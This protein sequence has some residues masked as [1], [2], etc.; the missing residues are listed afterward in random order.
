ME[1]PPNFNKC[2]S[3]HVAIAYN[4]HYV[5]LKNKGIVLDPHKARKE[6]IEAID[7]TYNAKKVR[8]RKNTDTAPINL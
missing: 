1:P 3:Y 8:E 2:A 4:I 6:E 7:P 5:Q